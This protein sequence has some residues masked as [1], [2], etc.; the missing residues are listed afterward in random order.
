MMSTLF[1]SS[2]DGS[3]QEPKSLQ[4]SAN[5]LLFDFN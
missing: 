4:R 1:G 5:P 2:L 3:V